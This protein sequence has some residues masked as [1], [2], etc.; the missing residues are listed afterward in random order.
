MGMELIQIVVALLFVLGGIYLLLKFLRGR[1]LPRNGMVEM[2]HYQSLG[3]K[4]G[5]AVIR[6]LKEYLVVGIADE[7]ISILSRP[8]PSEVEASLKN[9][10]EVSE[11]MP[12][13][14]NMGILK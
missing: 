1:I 4:K 11:Q 6:V 8:S 13:K 14:W 3:P 12:K 7:S 5:I 9:E 2:L 10:L